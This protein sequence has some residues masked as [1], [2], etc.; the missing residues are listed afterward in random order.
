[1]KDRPASPTLQIQD[2][3]LVRQQSMTRSMLR[4]PLCTRGIERHLVRIANLFRP[5]RMLPGLRRHLMARIVS[6]LA[7]AVVRV[8]AHEQVHSRRISQLQTTHTQITWL[9][10]KERMQIDT[11]AESTCLSRLE[12]VNPSSSP[13]ILTPTS[14]VLP[15]SSLKAPAPQRVRN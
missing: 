3:P 1:M 14:A 9:I 10:P 8:I 5:H 15:R 12:A 11:R 6:L 4:T 2:L 7:I 13:C